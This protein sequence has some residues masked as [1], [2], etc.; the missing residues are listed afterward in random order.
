MRDVREVDDKVR[1]WAY[2]DPD[3][4]LAQAR[5]RDA[6]R[7]EGRPIGPLH[8][9]P[10]GIKDI[11]DTEDMPTEDGSHS[12]RAAHPGTMRLPSRCCAR[13]AR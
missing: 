7:S 4:A 5:E 2:L 9:I 6:E 8:G 11:F 1:A 12:T 13:R 3:H 10:V